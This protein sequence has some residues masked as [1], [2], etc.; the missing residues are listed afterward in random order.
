MIASAHA[1]GNFLGSVPRWRSQSP[2]GFNEKYNYL[3]YLYLIIIASS[4]C[5]SFWISSQ[6]VGL[7]SQHPSVGCVT[8][9]HDSVTSACL[10]ASPQ[11]VVS[12]GTERL[13]L[14]GSMIDVCFQAT[15]QIFFGPVGC[16]TQMILKELLSPVT[17]TATIQYEFLGWNS[18]AVYRGW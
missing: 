14:R 12:A 1:A 17:A 9:V 6:Q 2:Y 7:K 11:P 10:V 8:H 18:P 16:N 3:S 15:S 5:P 4:N 13:L